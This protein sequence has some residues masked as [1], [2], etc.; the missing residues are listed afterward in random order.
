MQQADT[1]GN[2]V[3]T[4][5]EFKNV[6]ARGAIIAYLKDLCDN[7]D[8][9]MLDIEKCNKFVRLTEFCKQ[10]PNTTDCIIK[11]YNVEKEYLHASIEIVFHGEW[12]IN[13]Q[14]LLQIADVCDGI[15]IQSAIEEDASLVTFFVTNMWRF[16]DSEA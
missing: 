15:N 8:R 9:L 2:S 7:K 5:E 13:T 4:N 14:L 16:V 1:K 6:I 3:M 11:Q 10:L 12:E